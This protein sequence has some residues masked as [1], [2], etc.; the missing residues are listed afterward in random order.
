MQ[1]WSGEMYGYAVVGH[2]TDHLT[3]EQLIWA[4]DI[5][6]LK[7]KVDRWQVRRIRNDM[8]EAETGHRTK[9][10]SICRESGHT[11]KKYPTRN[12]QDEA[13]I[14]T[15]DVAAGTS[16]GPHRG[17]WGCDHEKAQIVVICSAC[18]WASVWIPRR[19]VISL[20]F[21]L[22]NHWYL[23]LSRKILQKFTALEQH[24]TI[25]KCYCK[26]NRFCTAENLRKSQTD[27]PTLSPPF[28]F[29]KN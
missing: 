12:H 8:D 4:A 6:K 1:T 27:Q 19:I 25:K 23:N 2:F 28:Y 7:G 14:G 26:S 5:D 9:K 13:D 15:P 11:F 18:T 29:Q 16:S 21:L 20:T 10:C 3:W 22:T 17:R 24:T